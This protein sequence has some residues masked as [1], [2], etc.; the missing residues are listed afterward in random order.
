LDREIIVSND[1][2]RHGTHRIT[3]E[4]KTFAGIRII[5]SI[6]EE[7]TGLNYIDTNGDKDLQLDQKKDNYGNSWVSN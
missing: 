4:K 5:R 6:A 2:E 3:R 1:K 7:L